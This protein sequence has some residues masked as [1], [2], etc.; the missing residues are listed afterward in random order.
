MTYAQR[1]RNR[2]KPTRP[3]MGGFWEDLIGGITGVRPPDTSGQGIADCIDQANATLAPF[4]AKVDDLVRTWNPTGFYTSADL[5]SIIGAT[6]NVVR[7]AQTA[8]DAASAEPNASQ[9]SVMRAT[10]DLARAGE[11][12]LTYLEA[13]TVADQQGQRV[14]NAPGFKRWVTDTMATA[15]S[16]MVT[17]AVIGCIKPWWVG[18]LAQFQSAFDALYVVAKRFVGAVIAIGETV[19]NVASDL[20][21]I[22]AMIKWPA[23]ALLGYWAWK[24]IKES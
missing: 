12:S 17:A 10:S 19:L 6:M 1:Y 20:P 4:D 24:Q 13:A 18:A 22:Y 8:V 11:R 16:G 9:D 21:D 3:A 14:I 5:R 7:Q 15:S 2:R 23:L